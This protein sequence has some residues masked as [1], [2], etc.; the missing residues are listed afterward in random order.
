MMEPDNVRKRMY[1][2]DW[3]TFLYSRTF[4]EYCKPAIVEKIKIVIK[5]SKKKTELSVSY[6]K[7]IILV[8]AS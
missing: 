3:V 5:K 8:R 4:T 7:Q 6:V 1:M 2:C